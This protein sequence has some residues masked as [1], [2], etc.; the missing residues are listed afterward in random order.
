MNPRPKFAFLMANF[1]STSGHGL[2]EP[3][4]SDAALAS[5]AEYPNATRDAN[6]LVKRALKYLKA[7]YGQRKALDIGSGYGFFSKAALEAGFKVIAVNPGRWEN[8][9]FRQ[10]TGLDPIQEAFEQVEFNMQFDLILMSQ[11]LE[12][13]YDPHTV[14]RK[15]ATLL[16]R[17]GVL[18]IAV[19]NF[20][21]IL[22]RL[23]KERERGVLWVPEHLNYFTEAGLCA[24]LASA[25]FRLLEIRRV[26]RIPYYALSKRL[27][28]SGI[29][30]IIT[31][32]MLR[33]GQWLPM[34]VLEGLGRG[35]SIQ[36][37][38]SPAPELGTSFCNP[39]PNSVSV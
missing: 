1:Y 33:I 13:I 11:V 2:T 19:P 34:R 30:L 6:M 23:L 3:I 5:E 18:A 14:L 8:A 12:H 35:L 24:L 22:V 36:V 29:L 26:A 39:T 27:H 20:R 17:Q 9:V 7:P 25:G 21:W 10:L 16:T 28:L 38:A 37:W 32:Y 4:S 15:V 31:N